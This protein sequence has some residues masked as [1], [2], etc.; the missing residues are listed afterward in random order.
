MLPPIPVLESYH[1]SPENGFL[2][3]IPPLVVLSDPYFQ[4]WEAIVANLQALLLTK[5]IRQVVDNLPVLSTHQLRDEPE[6][7][8]AY[9][10]LAF[11]AHAYIWGGDKPSDVSSATVRIGNDPLF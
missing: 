10:V 2:P 5:R 3:T 1:V 6:W 8:R 9:V 4:Q 7:R 11:I